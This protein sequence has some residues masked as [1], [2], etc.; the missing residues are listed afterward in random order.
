MGG[1][2]QKPIGR[3]LPLFLAGS[4]TVWAGPPFFT[5]DPDPPEPGQWEINLPWSMERSRNGSAS[6]EWLRVDVNY[7]YD[8][9]TQLSIEMPMPYHLPV[10]GGLRFGGGDVLLEYKR[11]FGL[12]AKTGYFGINPQLTLPTGDAT[13]GLGRR[14]ATLQLPLLYQ[15][16]WG[17]TVVY[18]DAR[19]K[20]RAGDEGKNY[21]FF[22]LALEHTVDERLKLGAE[23]F[24]TTPVS[25]GSEPNAG[26][27]LGGKW[28]L[29]PGRMLMLSA[30]RSFLNEPELTLF[31]G[32]KLLFSP[33]S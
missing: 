5:N 26:F 2:S 31:V 15:K 4:A 23:V 28:V 3:V 18:G 12:D 22:G 29:A 1:L 20:W 19:Y 9:Y 16:Q 10:E 21:W 11:R 32:L 7:G 14:R 33:D 13:R 8:R 24:A 27:N 25:P 30:G 17:D 6:G